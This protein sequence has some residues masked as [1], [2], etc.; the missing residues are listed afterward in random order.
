[1]CDEMES[2]LVRGQVDVF[3]ELERTLVATIVSSI[4]FGTRMSQLESL[5]IQLSYA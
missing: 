1:M 3:V 5:T 4:F 2:Y